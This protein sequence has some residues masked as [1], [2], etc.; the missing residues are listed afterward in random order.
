M[1]T[2][3]LSNINALAVRPNSPQV[4]AF[5]SGR[6]LKPVVQLFL[7]LQPPKTIHYYHRI[8]YVTI[9]VFKLLGGAV[10]VDVMNKWN[11]EKQNLMKL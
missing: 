9:Q 5:I 4:H 8:G 7:Q 6:T 10:I 1:G 11:R 3:A 2:C